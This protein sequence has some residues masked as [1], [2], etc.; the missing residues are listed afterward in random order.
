[1][2]N[3]RVNCASLDRES[4]DRVSWIRTTPLRVSL[5]LSPLNNTSADIVDD[6]GSFQFSPEPEFTS[7]LYI[8]ITRATD[9]EAESPCFAQLP[10]C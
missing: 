10:Q 4:L 8:H 5:L 9:T 6:V 7:P 2:Y 3:L 1:M